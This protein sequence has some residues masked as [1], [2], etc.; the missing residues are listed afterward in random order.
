ML[1]KHGQVG[2]VQGGIQKQPRSQPKP[3]AFPFLRVANV[4][5][6]GSTCPRSTASNYS[7]DRL[8]R[9]AALAGDMLVVEGMEAR[10]ELGE[11]AI[12]AGA[13]ADCVHQN[14]II[15]ASDFLL[16]ILISSTVLE[17]AMSAMVA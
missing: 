4:L 14:H 5:A 15:R 8:E 10:R 2:D 3:N 17:F 12:W 11:V 16:E 13:I 7:A 6:I 1:G 9:S